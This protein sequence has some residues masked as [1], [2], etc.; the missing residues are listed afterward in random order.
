LNIEERREF[1]IQVKSI[2]ALVPKALMLINDVLPKRKKMI[3]KERKIARKTKRND[4]VV[5]KRK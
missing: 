4:D 2:I 5:R 3:K 1:R